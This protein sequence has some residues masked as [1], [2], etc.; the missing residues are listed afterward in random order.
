M[1]TTKEET[2][3]FEEQAKLINEYNAQAELVQDYLALEELID[4]PPLN[5]KIHHNAFVD[6]LLTAHQKIK[7]YNKYDENLF[8]K[9]KK[10]FEK[11]ITDAQKA[12]DKY[13]SPAEAA[14]AYIAIKSNN[15]TINDF[16]NLYLLG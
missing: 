10:K 2:K 3:E 14:K 12:K 16:S 1:E 11:Q 15:V 9:I 5:L 8:G 7:T 6:E 13:E 4:F